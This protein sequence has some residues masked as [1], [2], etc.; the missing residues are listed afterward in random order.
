MTGKREAN[1]SKDT[2]SFKI[3]LSSGYRISNK[4]ALGLNVSS[5]LLEIS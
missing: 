5:S 1:R 2:F 3:A 4:E